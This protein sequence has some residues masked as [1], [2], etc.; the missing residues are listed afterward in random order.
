MIK[1]SNRNILI[2][3]VNNNE[4][5]QQSDILVPNGAI[6]QSE[7]SVGKT[8]AYSVDCETGFQTI[9]RLVIFPTN[10]AQEIEVNGQKATFIAE[11][12][13]LG[14]VEG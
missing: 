1:P 9:G 14:Y 7:Y 12:Y 8:L 11:N 10:M 13:V 3:I 6:R 5:Q 4:E 2:E